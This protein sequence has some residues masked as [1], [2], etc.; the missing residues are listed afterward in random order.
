VST[1]LEEHGKYYISN[2]KYPAYLL[3]VPK[4]AVAAIHSFFIVTEIHMETY[5]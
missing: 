1:L 3:N 5:I 4:T 2:K